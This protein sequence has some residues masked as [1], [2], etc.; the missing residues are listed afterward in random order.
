MR[1]PRNGTDRHRDIPFFTVP[2]NRKPLYLLL[3]SF[4]VGVIPLGLGSCGLPVPLDSPMVKTTSIGK[5]VENRKEGRGVYL[6]GTIAQTA[7]FLDNGAYQLQDETGTIWVVTPRE[8]P[9][10]GKEVLIRGTVRY[11]S[12]PIGDREF[13]ELYIEEK[14]QLELETKPVEE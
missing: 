10:S 6:Q 11:H 12:I 4:T 14:K 5:V 8:L 3:F 9:E 1:K 2:F 13:G 7:P